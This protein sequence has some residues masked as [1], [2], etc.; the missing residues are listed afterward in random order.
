MPFAIPC[1]HEQFVPTWLLVPYLCECPSGVIKDA[2]GRAFCRAMNHLFACLLHFG[3]AASSAARSNGETIQ[4]ERIEMVFE[5]FVTADAGEVCHFSVVAVEWR[6][7]QTV[8]TRQRDLD[9]ARQ[10]VARY[11][12][13]GEPK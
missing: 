1:V 11:F 4:C 12:E 5:P 7:Q 9:G 8:A 13:D 3:T 2:N 10:C 6:C